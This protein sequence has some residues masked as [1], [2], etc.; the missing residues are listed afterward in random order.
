MRERTARSSRAAAKP[1]SASGVRFLA[2]G[3]AARNSRAVSD[4]AFASSQCGRLVANT[5]GSAPAPPPNAAT[6]SACSSAN[7]EN[8][9][10]TRTSSCDATCRATAATSPAARPATNTSPASGRCPATAS[11][12]AS[13]FADRSGAG[14]HS[15]AQGL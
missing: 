3:T 9:T 6:K 1:I 5:T 7:S 2:L 4:V 8:A 10:N 11:P 12:P 15:R 13:S 14:T